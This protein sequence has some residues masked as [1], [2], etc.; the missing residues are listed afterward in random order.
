MAGIT[1]PLCLSVAVAQLDYERE[2]INYSETAA[3][4]R[5]AQL[6]ADLKSGVTSLTWEPEHGYLMSLLQTLDVPA[7]SQTLVFSKTSLQ[8][9]RISPQRPRAIYFNDDVYIGWVQQGDVIEI[10]A[11]DRNLGGTFYTLVQQ[12]AD[13]PEIVRE[14]SRCLQCHGSTHTRR[15]PGHI[16][17]SV[18]PDAD[19]H[20]VFRLGTHLTEAD[21]PFRERWGGWYVSGTYGRQRHLGNI[22]LKNPETDENTDVER[23]ANVTDLSAFFD[24]GPYLSPHSDIAALM[25]LQHQVF[26]HNALTAA[27]HAGRLTAYDA[28]M[29]NQTLDRPKDFESESTRHRYASAAE[30]V[31][32]ALLFCGEPPLTDPIEGTSRFQE[33]FAQ[34]GPFDGQGRSLRQTDLQTRLMKYPCSFLVYSEAFQNLPDGVLTRVEQRLEEILSG[35]DASPEYSHLSGE[36]RSAILEILRETTDL[37]LPGRQTPPSLSRW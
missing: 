26:V 20:P 28:A 3:T 18:Y 13:V 16:V 34:R 33:L 35:S 5:V 6:A 29:M 1:W 4:D 25:V 31:V 12:S 36:D 15:I 21:S 22:T 32:R 9:H 8:I 23:G 37:N 30:K 10:S 24:T 11:A 7:E 19:G 17:R 14:T 2:P 27:N